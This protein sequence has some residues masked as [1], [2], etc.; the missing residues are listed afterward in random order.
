[1][2]VPIGLLAAA[3]TWRF[4]PES[5]APRARRVDPVGQLLVIVLLASTVYAIIEGPSRGWLSGEILGLFALA[6]LAVGALVHYERRRVDPLIDVRFFAQRAV[7]RRDRDRDRR[8]RRARRLPLPE[9]DLPAERARPVPLPR[10][11]LH[12]ADGRDD[13]RRRT[14]DRAIGRRRGAH[15]LAGASAAARSCSAA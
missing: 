8:L 7:L 5:K 1:M 6:A 10:R 4:V 12:A 14:A 13:G 9:H 3:L 2:N 15:A 11:P